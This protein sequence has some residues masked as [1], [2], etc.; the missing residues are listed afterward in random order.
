MLN[1]ARKRKGRRL[2]IELLESRWLMAG[3]VSGTV[4]ASG[5]LILTGD[6]GDNWL[7]I[8]GNG[9]S[10]ELVVTGFPDSQAQPTTVNGLAT[11]VTFTGV[12]G[13][14]VV[15]MND[16]ND[17][18]TFS[19]AFIA[20][21]VVVDL[22]AGNDALVLGVDDGSQIPLS[23][24]REL[25]VFAGDGHDYVEYGYIQCGTSMVADFGTGTSLFRPDSSP[26]R[27][28]FAHDLVVRA[29]QSSL[30]LIYVAEVYNGGSIL[31]ESGSGDDELSIGGGRSL[32]AAILAGGGD[33]QVSLGQNLDNSAYIDMAG[34]NDFFSMS[35]Y[36]IGP[37]TVIGGGG[38]DR[39][40]IEDRL[41]GRLHID[42]GGEDDSVRF[43]VDHTDN[44]IV[45]VLSVDMG[46]GND[47][48]TMIKVIVQAGAVLDGG[49]GDDLWEELGNG[50]VGLTFRNFER[51]RFS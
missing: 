16:G 25:L 36:I 9:N 40:S 26:T 50:I 47:T 4:S 30:N 2:C 20:G 12:N 33:D 43:Q 18:V 5:D 39:I 21:A 23:M 44:V 49:P 48:L 45:G 31:V 22:G 15:R 1:W 37:V 32:N 35:A 42:T 29:S 7:V 11:P 27:A 28:S 17:R 10:G 8:E 38:N 6:A 34:G 46:F 41:Y 19:E 13:S 51:F 3:D 24:A 14:V